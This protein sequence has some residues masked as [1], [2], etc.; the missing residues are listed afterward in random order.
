MLFGGIPDM[1]LATESLVIE[2]F[3]TSNRPVT[4]P[5]PAAHSGIDVSVVEVDTLERFNEGLSKGLPAD[6]GTARP[7]VERRL[8]ALQRDGMAALQRSAVG[9]AT[10]TQLGVDRVP[11]IVFNKQAVV[12][13]LTDVAEARRRYE[14]W[15]R[16]AD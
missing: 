12:Y 15:R 8:A 3:T 2:V 16:T 7:E 13:G 5:A 4:L 9:L 6:L 1:V 11:A 14:A 10:A